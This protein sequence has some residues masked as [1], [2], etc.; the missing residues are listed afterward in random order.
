MNNN[1]AI[2]LVDELICRLDHVERLTEKN[3][4]E[5]HEA[6]LTSKFELKRLKRRFKEDEERNK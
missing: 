2:K 4:F 3:G 5:T 6:Y 1:G